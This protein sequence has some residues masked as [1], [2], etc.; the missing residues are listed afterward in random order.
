MELVPIGVHGY[1]FSF[2]GPK[3]WFFEMFAKTPILYQ[4]FG[5]CARISSEVL[6]Q[7]FWN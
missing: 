5:G 4:E 3:N 6:K 1:T 2:S 7:F